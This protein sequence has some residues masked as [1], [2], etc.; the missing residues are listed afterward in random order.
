LLLVVLCEKENGIPAF[1]GMTEGGGGDDGR[2]RSAGM[3]RVVEE[4]ER[5][6]KQDL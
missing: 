2:K 3:T 1:A 5:K 6:V 4:S